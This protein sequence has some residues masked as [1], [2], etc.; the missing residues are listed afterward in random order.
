M[1]STQ[2]MKSWAM[3]IKSPEDVPRAFQDAFISLAHMIRHTYLL[4]GNG[5]RETENIL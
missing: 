3:E 2:T 5:I 4:N 1:S